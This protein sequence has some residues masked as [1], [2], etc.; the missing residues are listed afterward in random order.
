[1]FSIHTGKRGL[2]Q[3]MQPAQMAVPPRPKSAFGSGTFSVPQYNP[4]GPSLRDKIAMAS[5]MLMDYDGTLGSGNYDRA[6][7]EFDQRGAA[8]KEAFDRQQQE[9]LMQAVAAGDPRALFMLSPQLAIGQQNRG[10]DIK[11][12]DARYADT[13]QDRRQDVDWR[14]QTYQDTRTD[15]TE[16]VGFRDKQFK[17][18]VETDRR[19]YGRGVMESDRNYQ[20]AA[21]QAAMEREK[22]LAEAGGG[23]IGAGQPPSMQSS[24]FGNMPIYGQDGGLMTIDYQGE[25]FGMDGGEQ[26]APMGPTG[27]KPTVFDKKFDEASAK[28]LADWQL[29]GQSTALQILDSLSRA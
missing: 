19:D 20:L 9:A 28:D 10:E 6:K 27:R 12:D 14:N 21:D 2:P 18:G 26:S 4:Q 13:R 11:R 16:D 3:Q 8:A 1:M 24:P 23:F 22:F 5:G 15:R 25:G 17:Y 7:G 29:N